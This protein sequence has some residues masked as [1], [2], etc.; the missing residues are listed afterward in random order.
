[1]GELPKSSALAEASPESLAVIM[2]KDPEEY[3]PGVDRE[4]IVEALRAQRARWDSTRGTGKKIIATKVSN[5]LE[6]KPV[7]SDDLGF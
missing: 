3:V 1:M 4:K 7:S 2:G 6:H 5:V